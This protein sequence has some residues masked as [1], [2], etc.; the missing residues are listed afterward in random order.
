MQ[1]LQ[2]SKKDIAGI[3]LLLFLLVAV[4]LFQDRLFYDPL[5]SFF[6][7][8]GK[9]LPPYNSVKLFAG[10]LFRYALN[11]A[12]SLG[13]LWLLFKDKAIIKVSALLYGA[14]FAVLIAALFIAMALL[15]VNLLVVFYIRRFLIQ[16]LFLILFVPAFYYQRYM[17]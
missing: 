14:F 15:D 8:D 17:K 10:L 1:K 13:I 9:V 6:R 4:R 12:F 16:P 2:L 7:S 5:I 3:A 11:T